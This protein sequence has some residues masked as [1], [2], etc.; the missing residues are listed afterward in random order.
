MASRR[1][2]RA[3]MACWRKSGVVSM[4]TFW[5]LRESN[6]EGRRRLSCGSVELQT[7]QGQPSVGTPIDVPEPRTVIFSG[8]RGIVSL[9]GPGN[10]FRTAKIKARCACGQRNLPLACVPAI[11]SCSKNPSAVRAFGSAT[12]LWPALRPA[13]PL[14]QAAEIRAH[15]Q[16]RS[17]RLG[18]GLCGG[19]RG[20]RLINLHVGQFQLAGQVQQKIFFFGSQLSFGFFVQGVKHVDELTGGFGINHGLTRARVGVSAENHGGVLAE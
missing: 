18:F 7:R 17:T 2:I 3:R 9:A 12:Y 8:A 13:P 16:M 6:R 20:N 10:Y 4:T 19:L 5:P 1:S 11:G 15:Y 14:V